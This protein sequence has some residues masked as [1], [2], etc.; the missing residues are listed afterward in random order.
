MAEFGLVKSFKIDNGELEGL[1]QQDCFVLGYE[2]CMIDQL[3]ESEEQFQRTVHVDN[4]SRI[5]SSCRDAERDFKM[6]WMEADK[7]ETWL[8][9]EVASKT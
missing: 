9:L 6:S 5:E 1:Q 7:S 4:R 8:F 3:L 2:L